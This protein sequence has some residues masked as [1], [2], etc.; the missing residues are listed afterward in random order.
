MSGR[1]RFGIWGGDGLD[2]GPNDPSIA[3]INP[4]ATV[5]GRGNNILW[6]E[7]VGLREANVMIEGRNPAGRAVWDYFQLAVKRAAAKP[8][9]PVRGVN[10]DYYV[11]A[12]GIGLDYNASMVLTL[13][14]ALTPLNASVAQ[15]SLGTNFAV[16]KW[17]DREW[18]TWVLG[19]RP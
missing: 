16:Q 8:R 14:L 17:T 7:L 13:K 3:Q 18:N 11:D 1:P 10:Y 19:S 12:K 15:D 9:S 2:I 4:R 5:E 6:Y